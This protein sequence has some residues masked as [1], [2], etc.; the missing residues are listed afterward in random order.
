MMDR[1]GWWG[2]VACVMLFTGAAIGWYG[3]TKE[4]RD[5]AVMMGVGGYRENTGEFYY[6]EVDRGQLK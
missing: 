1:D 4:M 2:V 5:D 3:A 6:K